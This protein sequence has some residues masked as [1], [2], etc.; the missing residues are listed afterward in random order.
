MGAI[1]QKGQKSQI[2]N[3]GYKKSLK[4]PKWQSED[5]HR[6]TDNAKSESIKTKGKTIIYTTLQRKH[7]NEL[8]ESPRKTE[9]EKSGAPERKQI[10]LHK[11]H[12]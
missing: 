5:V 11:C 6:R 8:H 12:N 1:K 10:L 2:L 3:K 4:V 9:S 7:K